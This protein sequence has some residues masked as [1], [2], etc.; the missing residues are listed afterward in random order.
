MHPPPAPEAPGG[1]EHLVSLWD[2][3]LGGAPVWKGTL[4]EAAGPGCRQPLAGI[5]FSW[6]GL[7]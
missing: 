2:R 4:L 3:S 5:I 1:Q 6:T 7:H